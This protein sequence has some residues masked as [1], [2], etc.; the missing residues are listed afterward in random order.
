MRL[1]WLVLSCGNS[2][3]G[4]ISFVCNFSQQQT[5]ASLVFKQTLLFCCWHRFL[6]VLLRDV[7]SVSLA[8]CFSYCVLYTVSL[9][10]AQ[11]WLQIEGRRLN[12]SSELKEQKS[13]SRKA[14]Q[15][16]QIQKNRKA[17]AEK[18][19]SGSRSKGTQKQKQR[20]TEAKANTNSPRVRSKKHRSRKVKKRKSREAKKPEKKQ[21]QR[22]K[23]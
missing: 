11:C 13:K 20:N 5:R 15:R 6:P 22:Q 14:A 7:N 4:A 2:Q 1:S 18:L 23:Q 21:K 9:L 17:K 16:K 8:I 3:I 10:F 19:K 12:L